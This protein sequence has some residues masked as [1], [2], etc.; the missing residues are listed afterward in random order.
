MEKVVAIVGMGLS[1]NAVFCRLIQLLQ[2]AIVHCN[3]IKILIFEENSAHFATGFAY[4]IQSPDYWTLNNPADG[5]KFI[6]GTESLTEWIKTELPDLVNNPYLPR[7]IVGRYLRAQYAKFEEIATAV[8]ITIEVI[9]QPVVAINELL[10]GRFQIKTDNLEYYSDATFLTTG[11]LQSSHFHH[12]ERTPGFIRFDKITDDTS[13][14]E[15]CNDVYIIGGQ[16][17]FVDA[18]LWLSMGKK[19]S[20]AIHSVTRNASILTTKG[21]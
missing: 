12:I 21:N 7:S 2:E 15:A 13:I 4:G 14:P 10:D 5:F 6:P 17:G 18:A 1:G 16:A 19:F 20:G 9:H 3:E 11:H 8:G